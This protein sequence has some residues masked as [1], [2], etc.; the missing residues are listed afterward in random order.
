MWRLRRSGRKDSRGRQKEIMKEKRKIGEAMSRTAD[1]TNTESWLR[2]TRAP[3]SPEHEQI[4]CQRFQSCGSEEA[5]ELEM[6][7]S[8]AWPK[9]V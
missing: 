2:E 1:S 8:A 7:S 4:N 5:L 3:V 6:I 9:G